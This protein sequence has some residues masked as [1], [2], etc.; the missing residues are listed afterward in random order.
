[1]TPHVPLDLAAEAGP[2]RVGAFR[3]A[4]KR[5]LTEALEARQAAA[6]RPLDLPDEL[7][8]AADDL[9]LATS[10]ALENVVDHAFAGAERPGTMS[11]RADLVDDVVTIVVA[12]DG[13]WREP[14]TAPTTRGRG[15][16]LMKNLAEAVVAHAH[17]GT[18][19]T[20]RRLLPEPA[21]DR[22]RAQA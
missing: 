4:L 22:P 21:H 16:T 3:R 14:G 19:V 7:A 1:M 11:L 17:G 5:W 15:I 20:L 2:P 10:E 8:D 6:G 13:H 9:V 18:T 12:D